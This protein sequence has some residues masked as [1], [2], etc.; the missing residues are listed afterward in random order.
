MAVDL[1]EVL[2]Q[3]VER[4]RRL[5]HDDNIGW[6]FIIYVLLLDLL[7]LSEV[8]H[9][10]AALMRYILC[11]GPLGGAEAVTCVSQLRV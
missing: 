5:V 4:L 10:A 7:I 2:P 1:A 9:G 11:S 3:D 6:V 8:A